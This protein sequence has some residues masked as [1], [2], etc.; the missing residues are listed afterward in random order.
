KLPEFRAVGSISANELKVA[1]LPLDK[2]SAHVEIA[3]HALVVNRIVAKLAGGSTLGEW[4]V[5]WSGTQPR[6]TGS[7]SVEGVALDRVGTPETVA[8][9][10]S[11]WA[12][13]KAQVS[14]SAH[15]EG[16]NATE[17]FASAAGRVEFQVSNGVSKMLT[18]DGIRPLKFQA[19]Q[20]A[21]EM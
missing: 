14:Y 8:G 21:A 12:N 6:F 2:F 20:G 1:D 19:L 11:D 9:Q 13:G 15:F 18:L 5:D 17:M 3:D 7:G 16:K 10:I 4:K